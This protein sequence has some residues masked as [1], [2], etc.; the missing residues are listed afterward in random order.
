MAKVPDTPENMSRC[1]CG[2]CPSFPGDGG[3][4]CAKG[5]SANTVNRRG[6]LCSGCANFVD[7]D[8]KDG[9]FCAAGAGE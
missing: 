3:F 2:T 1:I 8:L 9:Y 6:C 7:Y 5:K 4:Y